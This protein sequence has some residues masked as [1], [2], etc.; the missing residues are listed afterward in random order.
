MTL[1]SLC[2]NKPFLE[3]LRDQLLHMTHA[4]LLACAI[5]FI[6]H[7]I[8]ACI[9]VMLEALLR[10]LEQH[11]WDIMKVGRRDLSFYFLSCLIVIVTY[12]LTT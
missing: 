3:E 5:I 7:P 6:H 11:E 1:F 10:E 12:Y 9:V 2:G 8:F 4:A